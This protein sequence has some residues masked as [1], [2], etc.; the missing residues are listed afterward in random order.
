MIDLIQANVPFS[1][2]P[3]MINLMKQPR[4]E[5]FFKKKKKKKE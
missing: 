4:R 2:P 3:E 1:I 5:G